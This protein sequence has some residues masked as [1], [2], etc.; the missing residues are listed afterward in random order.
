[1]VIVGLAV[2]GQHSDHD[3][4]AG[5]AGRAGGDQGQDAAGPQH[6]LACRVQHAA[7]GAATPGDDQG[8]LPRFRAASLQQQGGAAGLGLRQRAPGRVEVSPGAAR[9]RQAAGPENSPRTLRPAAAAAVRSAAVPAAGTTTS[10]P[11]RENTATACAASGPA[12]TGPGAA[13]R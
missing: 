11:G 7:A 13:R 5:W 4:A 8:G 6:P 12:P 2:R 10:S 9:P 1:M 3:D